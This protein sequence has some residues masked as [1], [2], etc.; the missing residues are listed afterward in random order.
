MSNL[1]YKISFDLGAQLDITGIINK[2]VLPFL[3]QAVR[4]V[5]QQTSADWQEAVLK[6]KLWE[7]ERDAYAQSITWKMTGDFSG[8]VEATYKNAQEIETG[9]P[10]RDLKKMLDTSTKVRRTQS[11]KRFLVI[12]MRH[13]IQKLQSAGL[14]GMASALEASMVTGQGQRAS[15]EV[16]NLSP[17]TGMSPAAKQSQYLL[18]PKT[19]NDVMVNRNTY[20]WGQRLTGKDVGKNKW[21]KGMVRM[22]T[23]AGGA[24]SSAF[25]TFRIMME[26]QKGWVIPAQPG[27]YIAKKVQEQMQPKAEAA[28]A[29]AIK[30]QFGG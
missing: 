30:K 22:N 7:G 10:P 17:T 1:S 8:E 25:M 13:N 28:F 3:N 14:Y 27:L 18:N 4:A 9:R 6:S 2:Q 20:N 21:A 19:K 23:S 26:G 29:G 12:P 15:G 16:T 11:G 24:T 5:V